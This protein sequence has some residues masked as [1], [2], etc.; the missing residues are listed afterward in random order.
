MFKKHLMTQGMSV[1][2]VFY[3][4]T[5]TTAT[6]HQNVTLEIPLIVFL[7]DPKFSVNP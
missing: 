4:C 6:S 2:K 1:I 7:P 3:L 5:L